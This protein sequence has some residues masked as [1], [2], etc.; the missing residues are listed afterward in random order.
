MESEARI[1]TTGAWG[2]QWNVS[3]SDWFPTHNTRTVLEH[4]P[5]SCRCYVESKKANIKVFSSGYQYMMD[6]RCPFIRLF[7]AEADL[8]V[9]AVCTTAL[10]PQVP[11]PGWESR[12]CL[13]LNHS[14]VDSLNTFVSSIVQSI[15]QKVDA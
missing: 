7:R 6:D 5:R 8:L 12:N 4:D 14:S 9:E 3:R 11:P 15:S 10:S 2:V 1:D 13:L